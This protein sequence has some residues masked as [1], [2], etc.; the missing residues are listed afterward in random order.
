M[1]Q[2]AKTNDIEVM[3]ASTYGDSV[4]RA[5]YSGVKVYKLASIGKK[6]I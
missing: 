2:I 5:E 6:L 3:L 4:G 1:P